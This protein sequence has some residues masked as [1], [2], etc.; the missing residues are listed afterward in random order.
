MKLV[1]LY[2]IPLTNPLTAEGLFLFFGL[3][4]RFN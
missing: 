1:D 4:Q 3:I 2:G